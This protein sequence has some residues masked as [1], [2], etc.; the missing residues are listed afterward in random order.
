M[1]KT[2]LRDVAYMMY[3]RQLERKIVQ[4]V[5]VKEETIPYR[6]TK[7]GFGSKL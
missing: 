4:K 2:L 3:A 5:V 6:A 1:I 7:I